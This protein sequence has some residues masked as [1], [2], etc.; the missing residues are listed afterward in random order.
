MVVA[1]NSI[2]TMRRRTR[3]LLTAVMARPALM[4]VL[5]ADR[6]PGHCRGGHRSFSRARGAPPA[7]ICEDQPRIGPAP[8]S[9]SKPGWIDAE[10]ASMD[11]AQ[12]C[13]GPNRR[14]GRRV[15]A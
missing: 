5:P 10:R 1:M 3:L 12:A 7:T 15:G 13:A 6:P 9:N 11:R 4:G 2:V 8:R 14:R